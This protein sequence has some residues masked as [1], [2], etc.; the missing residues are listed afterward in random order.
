MTHRVPT[1]Q[2]TI[3]ATQFPQQRFIK[4]NSVATSTM[5]SNFKKTV[6]NKSFSPR[7]QTENL[8][9]K[10]QVKWSKKLSKAQALTV[11]LF[12]FTQHQV[13]CQLTLIIPYF[14]SYLLRKTWKNFDVDID[15]FHF[16]S[17]GSS[18]RLVFLFLY[19]FSVCWK[20]W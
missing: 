4:C 3:A 2:N 5:L 6:K 8:W 11:H 16:V 10:L 14:L 15:T 7:H 12:H 18:L 1:C 17:F 20:T 13:H 19:N 9:K